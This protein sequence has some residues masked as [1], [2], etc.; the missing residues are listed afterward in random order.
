MQQDRN[1]GLAHNYGAS[2]KNWSCD[3]GQIF[4]LAWNVGSPFSDDFQVLTAIQAPIVPC[5]VR[6]AEKQMTE[7]RA[8]RVNILACL[9]IEI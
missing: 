8:L 2:L 1:S 9:K 7:Y 4:G 6:V 3:H 5:E